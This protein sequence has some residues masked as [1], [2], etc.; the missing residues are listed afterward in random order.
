MRED[1]VDVAKGI[2]IVL[3]VGFHAVVFPANLGLVQDWRGF[4]ALLDTFRM[5]LFF[6]TS[7]L[8][9]APVLRRS[10]RELW[11]TRVA[12][13]LW[14]FVL[15]SV[16]WFAVFYAAPPLGTS[17]VSQRPEEL[18]L[19]LVSPNQNTWY[20][21][22]LALYLLAAWGL[23][24]LPVAVQISLAALLAVAFDVGLLDAANGAV[25]RMGRG[26][27]WFLVAVHLGPGVCAL[28]PRVRW[29]HPLLALGLYGGAAALVA[30]HGVIG[31]PFVRLTLAALAVLG[32]CA[33]AV[34]LSRVAALDWLRALGRRTLGVYLLHFY[35]ILGVCLL[36]AP[37]AAQVAAWRVFNLA[38]PVLLTVLA[39]LVSLAVH[40][41]ARGLTWL[42]DRPRL[43]RRDA[44]ADL[45]T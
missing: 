33:L 43:Q 2:A 36:L 20:V 21:Y 7:G 45:P 31:A 8:F 11:R 12:R 27:V 34:T 10:L 13:L 32:G 41:L 17:R 28:A 3:V 1:W 35:V 16:L 19:M 26:F 5:P 39:V 42:W 30:A 25:D 4:A 24:R 9:A 14:L 23:R 37:V 6:F 38:L 22:A 18:L 44:R 29:W 40:R 15:W